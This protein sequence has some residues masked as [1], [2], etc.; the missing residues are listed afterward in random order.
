MCKNIVYENV[1]LL[2]KKLL[3]FGITFNYLKY[4]KEF[5]TLLTWPFNT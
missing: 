4:S 5:I 2:I 3:E 1:F